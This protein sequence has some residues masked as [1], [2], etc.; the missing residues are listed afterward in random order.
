MTRCRSPFCITDI[1][2][3]K[4]REF[5]PSEGATGL[6]AIWCVHCI[7]LGTQIQFFSSQTAQMIRNKYQEYRI[8]DLP[9]SE[10]TMITVFARDILSELGEE[11]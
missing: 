5:E 3:R 1:Q 10:A 4:G 2:G 7:K 11:L 9:K 8:D 6:A